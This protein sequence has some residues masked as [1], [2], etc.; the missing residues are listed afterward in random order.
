MKTAFIIRM[1]YK[2]DSPKWNWRFAYFQS[3]VLPKILAQ[4]DQDFDICMR[5]NPHHAKQVKAL[6]SKIKIFDARPGRRDRIARQNRW[7]ARSYFIDFVAFEDLVGID[8]YDIQIGLD[9]D[10][11]ILRRD[12]VSRI[13]KEIQAKPD[14]SMHISFQPDVFCASSLRTFRAPIKYD[15]MGSAIFAIY[16]PEDVKKY[17]FAY[18]DSHLKMPKNMDRKVFIDEGYCAYS[19][20]DMNESTFLPQNLKQIML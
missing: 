4:D 6:S 5:V 8:R 17:I 20:H 19:V 12:F 3:M 14:K 9:T 18:H 10:D 1:H 15:S 7:K 13:K 11:L 16:Q 2:K